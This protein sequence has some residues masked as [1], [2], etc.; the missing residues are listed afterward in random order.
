MGKRIEYFNKSY[1]FIARV[2]KIF[3]FVLVLCV[4]WNKVDV[5]KSVS[6]LIEQYT[7]FV[8]ENNEQQHVTNKKQ[9]IVLETMEQQYGMNKKQQGLQENNKTVFRLDPLYVYQ[10]EKPVFKLDK[11]Y[12]N[13]DEQLQIEEALVLNKL[14][15]QKLIQYREHDYRIL[16][17]KQYIGLLISSSGARGPIMQGIS[18]KRIN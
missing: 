13:E 9:G 14:D 1:D 12:S 18:L 6:K 5:K 15:D 2:I 11:V 17:I 10:G 4:V 3:L 7:P 16:G 8:L